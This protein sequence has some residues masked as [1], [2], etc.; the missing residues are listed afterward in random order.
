[1]STPP[2]DLDA[3]R[4]VLG[5]LM[6]GA[7]LADVGL[8]STAF[9]RPAHQLIYEVITALHGSGAPSEPVAVA[10]ELRR[11]GELSRAGDAPYLHTCLSAVPAAVNAG[12]YASI[13]REYAERRQ[14][15]EDADRIRHAALNPGQDIT[16]VRAL[17]AAFRA[18]SPEPAPASKPELRVTAFS[19]I[20]IK[21]T[22]WLWHHRIPIGAL[23]LLPG[24][25]GTG[26]STAGAWLAAQVTKGT[27]PGVYE[28][29]PKGVFYA[30]TE[31]D[32]ERTIA[33][34]V[35]A[36]GAD[37]D[38]VYRIDVEEVSGG[39]TIEMIL[40]QH[41]NLLRDGI[42]KYEIA[43]VFFDPLM[44]VINGSLDTHKDRD[45]RSALEPLSA[46]PWRR[47]VRSWAWPTSPR[48]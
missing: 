2:S 34:R 17:V 19:Q 13:V 44:S 43:L 47:T 21:A 18:A 42:R 24:R 1:V 36:A 29:I 39:S 33:P 30:A 40:P 9:F 35:I 14:C 26:K 45:A 28:G 5:A 16:T 23:T 46:W 11:R 8:P 41:I 4:A 27:L 3:E 38:K 12:H 20:K 15:I 37:M 32:Y 7:P 31:D 25:E 22:E 6:S 10:D 48:R